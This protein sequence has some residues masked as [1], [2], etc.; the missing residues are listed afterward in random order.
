LETFAHRQLLNQSEELRANFPIW[1]ETI[2]P[3]LSLTALE[4]WILQPFAYI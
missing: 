4:C 3:Q 1:I 2:R